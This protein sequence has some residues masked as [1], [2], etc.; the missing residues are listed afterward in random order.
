MRDQFADIFRVLERDGHARIAIIRGAGDQAFTVGGEI[1]LFRRPAR[2]R[3][4]CSTI[5]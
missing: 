3:F 1:A 5:M 2:D 4:P